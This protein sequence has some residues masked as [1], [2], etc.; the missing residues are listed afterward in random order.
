MPSQVTSTRILALEQLQCEQRESREPNKASKTIPIHNSRGRHSCWFDE[1]TPLEEGVS[2][3]TKAQRA[4]ESC[5]RT[6]QWSVAE[7]D[8]RSLGSESLGLPLA[9]TS[10]LIQRAGLAVDKHL[11]TSTSLAAYLSR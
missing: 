7:A 11:E 1:N 9:V 5:L 3:E 10:A 8:P 2:L 6:F 4:E